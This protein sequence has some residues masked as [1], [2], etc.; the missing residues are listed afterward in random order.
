[1]TNA[2]ASS[3]PN[4]FAAAAPCNGFHMG[5]V[6]PP[7]Q[8]WPGFIKMFPNMHLPE[9]ASLSEIPPTRIY[10]DE[11]KVQYDYRMPII[12]NTGLLDGQWPIKDKDPYN[13]LASFDYWKKY[14]NIPLTPYTP[15]SEYE[16]G[17]HAD[18]TF[19][20][21]EDKRFLHHRWFG[22]EKDSPVLYEAVLAKRM[23]HAVDLRQLEIAW[24]FIKK[25][26]RQ[27]DGSL[28]C[29]P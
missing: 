28:V 12:Q 26:S 4:I 27:K 21:G 5:Y 29:A 23:P 11:K 24:A 2:L 10:S 16:S 14:N 20:S 13:C 17:L 18:E 19:Y 25:F 22:N 9:Y 15:Y 7:V 6:S 3:Y 1:M 8:A